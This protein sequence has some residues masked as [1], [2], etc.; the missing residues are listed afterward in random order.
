MEVYILE[1]GY[2][3]NNQDDEVMM[4][5]ESSVGYN[6]NSFEREFAKRT[7][8]NLKFIEREVERLHE[9]GVE[10]KDISHVFEVTQLINSFV[11]LLIFPKESYYMNVR[12]Y[13]KFISDEANDIIRELNRNPNK[14]RSSYQYTD[15]RGDNQRERLSAKT[16]A[17]HFR[18]AVA[19][20][21]LSILPKSLNNDSI[22]TGVEFS[23]ND[24]NGYEF[25]LSL[26]VNEIKILLVALC[27]LILS[28]E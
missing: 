3:Y 6:T 14:F 23:D 4:V 18:N 16:L 26:D 27:E 13:D 28:K 7:L 21:H 24:D 15:K 8:A 12:Y 17:R 19:H 2:K 9:Q 25:W 20:N 5:A 1:Y 22:I 10:D 11:G